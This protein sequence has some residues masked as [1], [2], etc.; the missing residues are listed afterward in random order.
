MPHLPRLLEALAHGLPQAVLQLRITAADLTDEV[1]DPATAGAPF[2][3]VGD[4]I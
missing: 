1:D 2:A 3:S 4:V